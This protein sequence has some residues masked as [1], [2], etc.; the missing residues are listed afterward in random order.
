MRCDA[1]PLSC[2]SSY[3]VLKDNLQAS[4]FSLVEHGLS[5][6]LG[7]TNKAAERGEA[8]VGL[9]NSGSGSANLS[10]KKGRGKDKSKKPSADQASSDPW[11]P[12]R[13]APRLRAVGLREC[14]IPGTLGC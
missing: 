10:Q 7:G 1:E 8:W 13:A 2:L 12:L 5:Q 9:S 3:V 4:L 6:C 14:P 11:W